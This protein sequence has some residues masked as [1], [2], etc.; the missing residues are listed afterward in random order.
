MN[1]MN[2]LEPEE[3]EVCREKMDQETY[4]E[5]RM[6]VKAEEPFSVG[7]P[8]PILLILDVCEGEKDYRSI[9]IRHRF[10]ATFKHDSHKELYRFLAYAKYG[11][12]NWSNNARRHKGLPLLRTTR[13]KRK[14]PL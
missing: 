8:L 2:W 3:W 4:E 1:E 7:V 14:H 5:F 13:N 6:F 11:Y 12:G 10:N 9:E